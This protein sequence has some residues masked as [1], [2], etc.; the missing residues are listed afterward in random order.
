MSSLEY[1]LTNAVP[2][3][4]GQF[5]PWNVGCRLSARLGVQQPALATHFR[6]FRVCVCAGQTLYTFGLFW[7]ECCDSHV[8]PLDGPQHGWHPAM[9]G[10]NFL[11]FI[12]VSR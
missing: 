2:G 4:R 3:A 6:F 7:I 5:V 10:D 12:D 1:W 9:P 11:N 8:M